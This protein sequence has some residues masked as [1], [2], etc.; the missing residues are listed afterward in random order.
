M[1]LPLPLPLPAPQLHTPTA[2]NYSACNSALH[3]SQSLVL[4]M[5]L[6]GGRLSGG[7]EGRRG[8]VCLRRQRNLVPPAMR[9]RTL[10][11]GEPA[12]QLAAHVQGPSADRGSRP[13]AL[14]TQHARRAALLR[15]EPPQAG[16]TPAWGKCLDALRP[17]CRSGA[18]GRLAGQRRLT[19]ARWLPAAQ[20]GASAGA[21]SAWGQSQLALISSSHLT[22]PTGSQQPC[23]SARTPCGPRPRA[24]RPARS[25]PASEQC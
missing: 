11:R 8:T 4:M 2:C 5:H 17:L 16:L 7:E 15:A 12:G 20:P 23:S 1:S 3:A 22:S 6:S 9:Q 25:C 10:S 14:H 21:R 24:P 18:P 13:G 19:G